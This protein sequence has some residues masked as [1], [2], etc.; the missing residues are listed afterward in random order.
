VRGL[1]SPWHT[2]CKRLNVACALFHFCYQ[3]QTFIYGMGRAFSFLLLV[4]WLSH[5][6][7]LAALALVA[8]IAAEGAPAAEEAEAAVAA[9]VTVAAVVHAAGAPPVAAD[10]VELLRPMRQ[11]GP[12]TGTVPGRPW[13]AARRGHL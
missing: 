13:G 4:P 3:L 12:S 6:L 1:A 5:A 8:P 10:A 7:R 11:A 2:A 9:G